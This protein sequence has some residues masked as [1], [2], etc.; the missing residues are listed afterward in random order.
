V[1]VGL[2]I[3]VEPLPEGLWDEGKRVDA[4]EEM[5]RRCFPALVRMCRRNLAG[6]GDAEAVAQEAFVRAWVSLDRFSGARP[7]WPWVATIARRLCI[8]HRRRQER[9]Q[10]NLHVQSVV[11]DDHVACPEELLEADE[12]YASARRALA[13]LK[14]AERRVITLRDI[15]GWSYAEI[16]QFEGVTIESIRG[17]LKRARAS[18]RKSYAK[19]ASGAPAAVVL[20]WARSTRTQ[21]HRANVIVQHPVAPTP[22]GSFLGDALVRLVAAVLAVAAPMGVRGPT[23]VASAREPQAMSGTAERPVAPAVGHDVTAAD[24]TGAQPVETVL[25]A[26]PHSGDGAPG[27]GPALLPP[28]GAV[29]PEDA[30]FSDVTP[31]PSYEQDGTIFAS[32]VVAESCPYGA[33]AVLFRSTDRGASWHRLPAAG[34][35]GGRLL[36]PPQYPDDPRLFVSGP[37]ALQVSEDGGATFTAVAPVGGPAAISPAFHDDHRILMGHA[38]GW[39]Y[40]DDVQSVQPSGVVVPS[41]SLLT[42]PAFSPAY[43]EDDTVFVGATTVG[44]SGRH[45]SAVFR[46][47]AFRC[48]TG[49]PLTGSVGVPEVVVSPTFA[50]DSVVMAWRGKA[51]FRASGEG[52]FTAVPLPVEAFVQDVTFDPRA[53]LVVAVRRLDDTGSTGGL[54]RSADGGGRWEQ[55]GRG[56]RLAGGVVAVAALPDGRILAAASAGGRGG[57]LCSTDD[58]RTWGARCG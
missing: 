49:L 42:S 5:Y 52:R 37:T 51:L 9:E 18:L 1:T 12:E 3:H 48:D 20:R 33:C 45:E 16:A 21:V 27:G 54:F 36:L 30:V 35:V 39:E 38:P 50:R 14:P 11:H 22:G 24:T 44:G 32:G 10:L 31:S 7:F 43:A 53:R 23:V 8:D 58:G 6:A 28:D 29:A 56:T 15:R 25:P 17:S 13:D 47:T 40:R 57:L 34:F 55:V 46:C 19:L 4:F 26:P 41:P 2:R